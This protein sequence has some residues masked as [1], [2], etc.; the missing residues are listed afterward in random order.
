[1]RLYLLP[2]HARIGRSGL[3]YVWPLGPIRVLSSALARK[4]DVHPI[5]VEKA[6]KRPVN[7]QGTI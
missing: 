6:P 2:Y 1:V 5:V 3:P 4:L 7:D